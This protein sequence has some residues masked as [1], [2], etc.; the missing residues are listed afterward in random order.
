MRLWCVSCVALLL[1]AGIS[2]IIAIY[3]DQPF[4]Y[5]RD[6]V[7]S[8]LT[9]RKSALLAATCELVIVAVFLIIRSYLFLILA[10]SW[11]STVFLLYKLALYLLGGGLP[12]ACLGY[13][14]HMAHLSPQQTGIITLLIIAYF[15][16]PSYYFL[17]KH[18]LPKHDNRYNP[19]FLFLCG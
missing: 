13:F 17:A 16:L 6:P 9:I 3:Q 18:D 4:L 5:L 19:C 14:S 11:L 7:I 8:S 12:C 2:K 10:I 1:L 15:M